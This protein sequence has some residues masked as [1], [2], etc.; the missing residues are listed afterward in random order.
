MLGH[1]QRKHA[2][3]T[4]FGPC[5]A[6]VRCQQINE[7]SN[8]KKKRVTQT[9][10]RFVRVGRSGASDAQTRNKRVTDHVTRLFR[11]TLFSSNVINGLS[12][13]ASPQAYM[14]KYVVVNIQDQTLTRGVSLPV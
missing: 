4:R 1:H 13:P 8:S 5:D 7:N 14:L 9:V 2:K 12:E 11:V 10:T 3:E 6:F